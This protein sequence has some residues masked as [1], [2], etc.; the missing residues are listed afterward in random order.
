MYVVDKATMQLAEGLANS[1]GTSFFAL[2]QNAGAA[3]ADYII[4]DNNVSGK[5]VLIICGKGN[6]GGD[7]FVMAS[8]ILAAGAKVFVTLPLGDPAT[9]ISKK[10][11]SQMDKK[12]AVLATDEAVA[13]INS[14]DVIIDA[15]FGTGFGGEAPSGKVQDIFT[16]AKKSNY[17]VDIPSGLECD[18]GKGYAS[19]LKTDCTLTFA[20]KKLCHVL[21][22]SA[23]VCGNVVCLDIGIS[24]EQL[25]SAGAKIKE[26]ERPIFE[27]RPKTCHKNTFGTALT[28]TGSYGMSGAA[29]LSAKAALR[30]GVGL[31]KVACIE[32]N[33]TALAVSVPEAI[34]LPLKSGGKTYRYRDIDRLTDALKSASALLIGCGLSVNED[35]KKIIATLLEK[36]D[37]PVVLDADG[38]NAAS[39]DIQLLKNVKAPVIITPHPAE[40]ARLIKT[41]TA[42][43]EANRFKVACDFSREYGVYTVLKGAN[44]IIASPSGRLTVGTNGNP[45]L[46]SAG[47]GDV[48]SG[49]L[50]ALLAMGLKPYEAATSAVWLHAAA[51]DKAKELLGE[52]A[53]LPSD[54][55][56]SLHYFL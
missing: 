9:D 25:V 49:I 14:F 10:A 23:D 39:L 52:R 40:M 13:E 45:G 34:L 35:T 53:M 32:E 4:K 42:T 19:A 12:V 37:V 24:E 27:K 47:S 3:A 18:N 33:Y 29:I 2:M 5:K 21:P 6:N 31:L 28:V 20:A 38:I 8:H 15:V 41:D 51:G 11:F 50:T 22:K 16:A 1:S 30:T 36:S 48:L 44:T 46:A 26:N 7:G 17:A 56:G 43:V 54:V 55:I